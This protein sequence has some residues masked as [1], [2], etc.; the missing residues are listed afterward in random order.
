[1]KLGDNQKR[2]ELFEKLGSQGFNIATLISPLSN[3]STYS[4]VGEGSVVFPFSSVEGMSIIGVGCIISKGAV[5]GHAAKVGDYCFV[6]E[7]QL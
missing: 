1:M 2:C 6:Y 3:V 4:K 5:A 7:K